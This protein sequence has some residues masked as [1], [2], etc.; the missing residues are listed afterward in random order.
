[1]A[2]RTALAKRRGM[3]NI[4]MTETMKTID[5]WECRMGRSR[6]ITEMTLRQEDEGQ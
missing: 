2:D 1:M 4:A 5:V 3:G 6:K